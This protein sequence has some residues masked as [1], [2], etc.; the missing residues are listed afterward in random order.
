MENNKLAVLQAKKNEL[1]KA[2]KDKQKEIDCF[3]VS[4]YYDE[5]MFID[6]MREEYGSVVIMG[7]E[8]DAIDTLRKIDNIAF[9]EIYNNHM[10]GLDKSDLEEYRELEEE[11][12]DL[13]DELSEIEEQIEQLDQLENE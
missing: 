8:Y 2:I 9:R 11:L 10:D 4:E 13:E 3:D 1:V 6:E 12:E 5:D 7:C